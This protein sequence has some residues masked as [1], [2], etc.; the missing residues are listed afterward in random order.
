MPQPELGALIAVT[1]S[2]P[3]L[4][5]VFHAGHGNF[6]PAALVFD[7]E[8]AG[9]KADNLNVRTFRQTLRQ[10]MIFKSAANLGDLAHV[11]DF[12]LGIFHGRS[13]VPR[14]G[15]PLSDAGNPMLI[16]T[17]KCSAL[18]SKLR[19]QKFFHPRRIVF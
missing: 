15:H 12:P 4:M 11:I 10:L 7:I 9:V 5:E 19:S 2:V 14:V 17:Q 6:E 3:Q 1:L 16:F 8:M 13:L 18:K